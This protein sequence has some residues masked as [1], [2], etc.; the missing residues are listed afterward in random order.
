MEKGYVSD[1]VTLFISKKN[2]FQIRGWK[3]VAF[4]QT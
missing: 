3:N 2:Q 4:D 1:N